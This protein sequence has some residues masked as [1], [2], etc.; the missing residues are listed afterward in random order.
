MAIGDAD[1]FELGNGRWTRSGSVISDY[2]VLVLIVVAIVGAAVGKL[3]IA[4]LCGLVLVLVVVSRLWS[5]LALVDV[6]Y[7]CQPASERLLVGDSF[8]LA[9]T[10][11]NRK[12]LPLPWVSITEFVPTGLV[13]HRK[14]AMIRSQ[15]GLT[16]IRETT[17]LSQYERVTFH[18]RLTARRRGHYAFGPSRI[19]SGD[20]FG[21]YEA[22]L[23]S[24]RRP[25]SLV[26]YPQTV[27]LPYLNLHSARPIGDSLS[28]D[29]RVDDLTRPSGVRDYRPGDPARFI[30]WKSTA[31]RTNVFV[32][33]FDPS[34]AQ[35]V[36]VL[37]E[38]DTSSRDRWANRTGLLEAAVVG[39]ASV[40][41]RANELGYAVGIALNG[42]IAGGIASP[43]VAP[44]AGPDQ[45]AAVMTTLA[46]ATSMTT[47]PL[48]EV[49]AQHGPSA[50]PFGATLIYVAGEFRPG[51]TDHIVDL[52]Q[53]GYRA[54]G[55]YVGPDDPPEV[56][57]L[58]VQDYRGVF[59][60][61]ETE[62]G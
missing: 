57:G 36:M 44:G 19:A 35:R 41:V 15:F 61:A 4:T 55:I 21:F 13:L 23:G 24:H 28:R 7:L 27:P 37:V 2:I 53:R 51:I 25:T 40:A 42:N 16:E 50:L 33:T 54:L 8:D 58:E 20:I 30:D 38:C 12:P 31:K 59:D 39:A 6:D 18:H 43:V 34:V 17:S 26:V 52:G 29:C 49:L 45:V 48:E 60:V 14:D 1:P 62:D 10:V 22:R 9:L 47:K 3:F 5:R 11:E 32:R 46:G 56:P